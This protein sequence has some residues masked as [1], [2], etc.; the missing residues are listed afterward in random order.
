M[1]RKK[2][3]EQVPLP[4]LAVAASQCCIEGGIGICGSVLG[5]WAKICLPYR[6]GEGEVVNYLIENEVMS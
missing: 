1:A 4:A 2:R 3:K 6:L 5:L